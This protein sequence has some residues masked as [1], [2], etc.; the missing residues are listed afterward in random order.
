MTDKNPLK[1]GQLLVAHPDLKDKYFHKT[2][3]LITESH[4]GGTVGLILNKP[5]L[6]SVAEVVERDEKTEWPFDDTMYQGGPVNTYSLI[7]IHTA[8]WYSSNTLNLNDIVSITS[9]KFMLEKMAMNNLPQNY[10]FVVGISG[11][12]PGQ[13]EQEMTKSNSWLTC[14]SNEN[15]IFAYSGPTQWELAIELCARQ[16]MN[17]FF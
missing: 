15:I 14:D 12:S 5:T 11:W 6:S 4:E 7:A 8:E 17:Q 1:P 3:I 13:L 16:T 10:R 9:D 2:V